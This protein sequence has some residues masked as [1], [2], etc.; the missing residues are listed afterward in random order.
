MKSVFKF[1]LFVLVIVSGCR[2]E[3]PTKSVL[4][5]HY[6]KSLISPDTTTIYKGIYYIH[7]NFN[8]PYSSELKELTLYDAY[9]SWSHPSDGGLG[10]TAQSI[11][12]KDPNSA[13][14]LEIYL[15]FNT[16]SDT[17]FNIRYADYYFS[18]PWNNVA[19]ANIYFTKPV[20]EPP[21]NSNYYLYLGTNSTKSYFKITYIGKNRI[22]G[23]FSAHMKECCGGLKT[24]EATGDFSVPNTTHFF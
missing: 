5:E 13:M 11:H 8:N 7:L 20:N 2:K 16:N 21:E 17:I 6:I 3:E 12:F 10:M 1:F 22:N 4:V 15:H 19:G 24:Y 23:I 9:S 18:E 14:S